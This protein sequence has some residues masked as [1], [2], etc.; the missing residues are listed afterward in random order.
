[1]K[2]H[3]FPPNNVAFVDWST[4]V[5]KYCLCTSDNGLYDKSLFC[6][7][8]FAW[9]KQSLQNTAKISLWPKGENIGLEIIDI[10]VTCRE[11]NYCAHHKLCRLVSTIFAIEGMKLHMARTLV[12][13]G[14]LGK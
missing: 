5:E 7:F 6:D 14:Q 13:N 9:K 2:V 12:G 1:V 4:K 8:L 11:L 10:Y 3:D